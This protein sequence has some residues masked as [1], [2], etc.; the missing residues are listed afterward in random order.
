MQ[1]LHTVNVNFD[2]IQIMPAFPIDGQEQPVDFFRRFVNDDIIQ[3]LVCQT[4]LYAKQ[5]KLKH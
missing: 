5:L 4:N 3:L 2:R 1:R